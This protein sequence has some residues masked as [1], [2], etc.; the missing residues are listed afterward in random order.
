MKTNDVRLNNALIN[1]EIMAKKDEDIN[2][3]AKLQQKKKENMHI[4]ESKRA[5]NVLDR[6]VDVVELST[7]APKIEV[8]EIN[9]ADNQEIK[10]KELDV[11]LKKLNTNSDIVSKGIRFEKD[12]YFDKIIV[13]VYN[14]ETGD[15]IKQ[16]PPQDALEFAKKSEEIQGILFDKK[17]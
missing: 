3:L 9:L 7:K 5:N 6:K 13:K 17:I 15:E 10:T 11:A 16:I 4:V 2:E 8:K 12:N 1:S 14:S